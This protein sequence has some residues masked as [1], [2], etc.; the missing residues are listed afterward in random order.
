MCINEA[1][2]KQATEAPW[3]N[4]QPCPYKRGLGQLSHRVAFIPV[5]GPPT[6]SALLHDISKAPLLAAYGSDSG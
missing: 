3:S 4:Y 5:Q 2:N 6:T 1:F